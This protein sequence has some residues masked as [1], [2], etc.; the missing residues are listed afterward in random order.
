[1]TLPTLSIND[2]SRKEG[3]FWY[4]TF[5]FTVSL[6]GTNTNTV[7]VSYATASGTAVSG[8]DFL[9]TSGT[10]TFTPSTRSRTISVRVYGDRLPEA[11]EIFF[12]NLSN[13]TNATIT[14]AQG[15][16]TILNDD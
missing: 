10:L 6:S 15:I 8:S 13:A 1:M 14:K 16:G 11:N 9:N 7:T 3:R 5:T 12:V 2:V 4:S